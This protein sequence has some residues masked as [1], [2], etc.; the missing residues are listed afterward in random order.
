MKL[1]LDSTKPSPR[2]FG[3]MDKIAKASSVL[4]RNLSNLAVV[5]PTM[6]RISS[7][8]EMMLENHKKPGYLREKILEI[9]IE[10]K[11]GVPR[12]VIR[13][14]SLT[15]KGLEKFSTKCRNL[16]TGWSKKDMA[17][18]LGCQTTDK[19]IDQ[20][21]NRMANTI[22]KAFGLMAGWD[23]K[24]NFRI[25][26]LNLLTLKQNRRARFQI[27]VNNRAKEDTEA[28]TLRGKSPKA[29]LAIQP[30]IWEAIEDKDNDEQN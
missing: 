12:P 14:G 16:M 9:K 13:E 21:A 11:N 3:F 10:D 27:S 19:R 4:K 7:V 5:F 8:A 22:R 18:F 28:L 17:K 23:G 1:D 25:F 2:L 26:T 30:T 24:G 20:L 29:Q 6:E 15:D